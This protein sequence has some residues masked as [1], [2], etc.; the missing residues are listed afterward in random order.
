MRIL[1]LSGSLRADSHNAAL[2][3]SA[4]E[5]LPGDA[6]LELFDGLRDVPPYDE[7][8]DVEPAPAAVAHLRNAIAGA[9]AILFA[10]PEYNHSIPGQL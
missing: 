2:L 6:E 10:T 9:D 7:D 8:D 4:A 5:L 3:R 1:A